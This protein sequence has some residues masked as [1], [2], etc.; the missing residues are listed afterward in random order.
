MPSGAT[1]C[2]VMDCLSKKAW[3][4][5]ISVE[6]KKSKRMLSNHFGRRQGNGELSADQRKFCQTVLRNSLWCDNNLNIMTAWLKF[7]ET[8]DLLGLS[9]T[10]VWTLRATFRFDLGAFG[11]SNDIT[12][13]AHEAIQYSSMSLD[14]RGSPLVCAP[15]D[16]TAC[17]MQPWD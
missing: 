10:S 11:W 4:G 2:P 12:S 9:H 8:N 7:I 6:K 3:L 17:V 1:A 16:W 15:F 13:A 5:S 14:G